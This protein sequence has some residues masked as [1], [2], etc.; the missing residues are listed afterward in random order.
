MEKRAP[1]WKKAR[2]RTVAWK[3]H[4]LPKFLTFEEG[5]TAASS[6]H[7]KFQVSQNGYI[8]LFCAKNLFQKYPQIFLRVRFFRIKAFH[9]VQS[10][11]FS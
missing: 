2:N 8:T 1:V 10:T 4:N 5:G 6:F 11:T 3:V 7:V 9:A